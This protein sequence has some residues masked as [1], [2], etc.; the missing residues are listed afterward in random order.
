MHPLYELL[1]ILLPNDHAEEDQGADSKVCSLKRPR[2]A[3]VV[4]LLALF[5]KFYLLW[6]DVL[7]QA[8]MNIFK[9]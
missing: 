4:P 8:T 2:P 3:K 9:K 1:W 5:L 6:Y 7:D